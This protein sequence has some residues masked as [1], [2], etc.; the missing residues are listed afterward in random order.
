MR[1]F[2]SARLHGC[3]ADA[4][5]RQPCVCGLAARSAGDTHKHWRNLRVLFNWLI[6]EREISCSPMDGVEAPKVIPHLVRPLSDDTLKAMLDVCRGEAEGTCFAGRRD[7]AIIRILLDNG[8]RVSGLT[9]LR[10]H[11]DDPE[12]SDVRLPQGLLRVVLKGGR[13][14]LAPISATTA[15]AIDRYVRVRVHH[16]EAHSPYLFLS[17][18]GRA[19]ADC[20]FTST[21]VLQMLKRRAKQAGVQER[22]HTH[23][24]RQTMATEYLDG[25]GDPLDL[26]RIGGWRS[27]AMVIRYHDLIADA[28]AHARLA[29]GE[30]R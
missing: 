29:M 7:E 19:A 24:L 28:P 20:R 12:R 4:A 14:H 27:L 18:R 21:G 3:W 11:P 25:G 8:M 10:F 26:Q 2:L 1:T 17:E 15:C 30:R 16:R 5:R 9:G 23:L 6:A 13:E 22:V